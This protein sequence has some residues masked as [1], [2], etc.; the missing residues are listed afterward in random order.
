MKRLIVC[1]CVPLVSVLGVSPAHAATGKVVRISHL[2]LVHPEPDP[3]GVTYD[4]GPIA[5]S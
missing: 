2:G 1:L 3:M 4:P 5:L